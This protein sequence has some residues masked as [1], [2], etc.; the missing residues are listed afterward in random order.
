MC[1]QLNVLTDFFFFFDMSAQERGEG[2]ELVTSASLS[3]VVISRN[4]Y[5]RIKVILISRIRMIYNFIGKY[6]FNVK[7]GGN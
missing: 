2:F 7:D 5:P 1:H 6:R 3:V 4:L